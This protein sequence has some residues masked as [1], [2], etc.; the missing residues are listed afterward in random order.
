MK[1]DRG[2]T[3]A[4]PLGRNPRIPAAS[5]AIKN[6]ARS[7]LQLEDDAVICV[8]EL[9]CSKPG[10]PPRETVVLILR[11]GDPA[12]RLSIHKAII[13]ICE[14]DVIEASIGSADI[15]PAK[16]QSDPATGTG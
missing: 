10:C 7:A 6:W 3:R 14:R 5:A 4:N 13:D 16:R 15:L 12:T 1:L 9:S 11:S 8:N 2:H